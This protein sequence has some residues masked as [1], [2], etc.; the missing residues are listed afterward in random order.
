MPRLHSL[1]LHQKVVSRGL[2]DKFQSREGKGKVGAPEEG[3]AALPMQLLQ[4]PSLRMSNIS[5]MVPTAVLPLSWLQLSGVL[6]SVLETGPPVSY[7]ARP[8]DAKKRRPPHGV[9]P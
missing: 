4:L 9:L 3:D 1:M 2:S 6:S 7:E 8:C 5:I